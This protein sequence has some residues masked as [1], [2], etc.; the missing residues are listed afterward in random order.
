MGYHVRITRE[1]LGVRS[2]ILLDEWLRFVE[3]AHL[4]EPADDGDDRQL[5]A[6][7]RRHHDFRVRD[8]PN[9]WL[10]WHDGEIWTTNP[11]EALFSRMLALAP[12]F[13]ARVAGDEGE[14]YTTAEDYVYE[15]DGRVYSRQ[16][17]QE[18]QAKGARLHRWKGRRRVVILWACMG[19]AFM[20][21]KWLTE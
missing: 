5:D 21:F 12:A 11:D 2:P 18:R 7:D 15:I 6:S 4:F 10:G 3:A 17:W 13:G 1:R 19:L 8:I 14:F 16:A 20:L 9:S